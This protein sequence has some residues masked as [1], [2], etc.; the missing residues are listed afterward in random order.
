MP[1]CVTFM[2]DGIWGRPRRFAR[3]C[4]AIESTCGPTQ[5]FRY[6]SSGIGCL[7]QQG[8]RLAEE[9]R[10]CGQPVNLVAFSM[11]G[12]V[13]RAAQAAD[14]SL[15]IRRVVFL[16]SPHHGSIWCYLAWPFS[17]L[18]GMRQMIPGSA[19]L[20][21]LNCSTWNIPTM[22]VWCP[23]DLAVVPGNMAKW[24]ADGQMVCSPMPLHPWPIY[25]PP[26]R[27]RI[28]TFLAQNN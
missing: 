13:V 4:R 5:I 15:P 20:R 2:L 8:D 9:I 7:Q 19:F 3:M 17:K 12:L 1:D 10:R 11:G 27:R 26:L 25:S 14:P 24:P 16:N 21:Q 6:D 22:S 23:L 28:A 18:R